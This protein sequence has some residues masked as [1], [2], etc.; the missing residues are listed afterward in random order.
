MKHLL[1]TCFLIFLSLPLLAQESS[2]DT[3]LEIPAPVAQTAAVGSNKIRRIENWVLGGALMQWSEEMRFR[4]AGVTKRSVANFN[5]AILQASKEYTYYRIGWSLGAFVGSGKANGDSPG[6]YEEGNLVFS[7]LGAQTRGF[8]R[9]NGRVNFGL[10]FMIFNRNLAWPELN[11]VTAESGK[12][13]NIN[14]VVD[15]NVR[16]FKNW[17]FYQGIGPMAEGTTLWKIGLNYRY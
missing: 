12:N 17:D 9:L 1:I 10:S 13:P 15:L 11:G 2:E 3:G 14:G 4:Q 5:G 8:Y 7:V 6:L 16:L